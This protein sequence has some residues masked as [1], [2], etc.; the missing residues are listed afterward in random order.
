MAD[1]DVFVPTVLAL[2]TMASP[3]SLI[4]VLFTGNQPPR[5]G[6]VKDLASFDVCPAPKDLGAVDCRDRH[7]NEGGYGGRASHSEALCG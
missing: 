4:P 7:G 3:C 1:R 5:V 2:R 6:A